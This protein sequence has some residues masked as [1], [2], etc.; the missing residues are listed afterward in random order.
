MST[1]QLYLKC[2]MAPPNYRN[3]S[4]LTQV[5][6][7][8]RSK[9]LAFGA[10]ILDIKVAVE[11]IMCEYAS[12]KWIAQFKLLQKNSI[13]HQPSWINIGILFNVIWYAN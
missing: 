2:K 13:T 4:A 11:I 12:Q 1:R 3:N 9:I 8:T 10:A 5:I 7:I 6:K